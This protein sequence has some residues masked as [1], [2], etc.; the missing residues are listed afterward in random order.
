MNAAL[1][2]SGGTGTRLGADIPKQ[3]IEVFGR[4]I[5]SYCIEK[6]SAHEKIDAIQIVAE[7]K[8]QIELRKWLEIYD[9]KNK[10]KGF[11]K[12][13]VNRQMSILNGL[14]DINGYAAEEDA[15]LI[16]DAAR[17]LLSEK[18]ITACIMGMEGCDG[19]LPVLPMKDTVYMSLD[20][21]QVSSLLNRSSIFAGQAPECFVFGKYL[22]ANRRLLPDK[23]LEINGS[24]EPAVMAGMNIAMIPGDENNFKITTQADLIRFQKIVCER[25]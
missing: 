12:P 14:E 18:Q 16:H 25:G 13:G 22:E 21:K 17:P 5:I 3:Y 8:W 24:T 6:L 19:V 1:I 11:S 7:E 23:I 2:L 4:N 15:V 9:L 10:F 20:G